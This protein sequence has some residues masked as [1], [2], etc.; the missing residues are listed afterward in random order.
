MYAVE[1]TSSPVHL[2]PNRP[3]LAPF[4]SCSGALVIITLHDLPQLLKFNNLIRVWHLGKLHLLR[5]L[6]Y[7]MESSRPATKSLVVKMFT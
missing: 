2:G 7:V 4:S 3:K 1:K 6:C 5:R